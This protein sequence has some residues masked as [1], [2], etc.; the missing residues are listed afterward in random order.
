MLFL[1]LVKL[2]LVVILI[3]EITV[4]KNTMKSFTK[5]SCI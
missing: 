4:Y 5:L 3:L 2:L 1:Q